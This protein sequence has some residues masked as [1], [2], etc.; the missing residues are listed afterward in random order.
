MASAHPTNASAHRLD[1]AAWRGGVWRAPLWVR[2]A[3]DKIDAAGLHA[4]VRS[5]GLPRVELLHMGW[6]QYLLG[7]GL[8]WAPAAR[9]APLL[10]RLVLDSIYNV[11]GGAWPDRADEA[12]SWGLLLIEAH[13]RRA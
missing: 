6:P 2:R 10:G 3:D 8:C 1:P 5:A 11:E 9:V 4:L 12:D 13:F 7:D